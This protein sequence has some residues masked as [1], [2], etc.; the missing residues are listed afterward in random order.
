MRNFSWFLDDLEPNLFLTNIPLGAR[1]AGALLPV[2]NSISL[3][4]LSSMI[5]S[6]F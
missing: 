3:Q 5:F 4:V 1:A 2:Q 6:I